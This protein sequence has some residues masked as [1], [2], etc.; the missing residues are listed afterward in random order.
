LQL[1]PGAKSAGL[2]G[3]ALLVGSALFTAAAAAQT[4]QAALEV[5]RITIDA[6]QAAHPL[7]PTFFGLMVED[8]NHS[9]HGGLY[10]ELVQNGSMMASEA[11]P[12]QWSAVGDCQIALDAQSPLNAALSRSLRIAFGAASRDHP[13][14]VSN[15][16][17]W[18]IPVVPS[19]TYTARLFAKASR[20]L[21]GPLTL[22]IE[23]ADGETIY[24]KGQINGIDK[25]WRQ[26]SVR[27][28][29]A[30]TAPVTASARFV[31]STA[32]PSSGTLWLDSVSLFPETYR[33]TNLRPDLMKMLQDLH[34]NLVR[35][36]GG[37]PSVPCGRGLGTEATLAISQKT[38][39]ACSSTSR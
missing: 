29:A 33:N 37:G 2:A 36:P 23:S 22:T 24:A 18:G 1:T 39:W 3:A 25:T 21:A 35:F 32:E 4:G 38:E 15:S 10:A 19:R 7:P 34:L 6:G 14:G 8:I 27:L 16:G 26:L 9:M 13:A 11:E 31:L 17:Y 20:R 28:Q 5:G 12:V 30:S